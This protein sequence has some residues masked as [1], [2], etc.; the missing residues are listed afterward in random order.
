VHLDREIWMR[1]T[2]QAA[3]DIGR[4]V[5]EHWRRRRWGRQ[6]TAHWSIARLSVPW[7]RERFLRD[8]TTEDQER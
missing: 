8:T 7:F 5:E 6:F 2:R 4:A 1:V 3:A